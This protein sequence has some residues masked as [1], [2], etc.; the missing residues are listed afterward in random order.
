ML[1]SAG[2]SFRVLLVTPAQDGPGV[3]FLSENPKP[4][5]VRGLPLSALAHRNVLRRLRRAMNPGEPGPAAAMRE[6]G[7]TPGFDETGRPYREESS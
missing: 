7:F 2:T 4:A 3:V 6:L 5:G 1:F